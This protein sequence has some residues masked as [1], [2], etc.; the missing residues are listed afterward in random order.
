MKKI[1]M[2]LMVGMGAMNM[3]AAD[4]PRLHDQAIAGGQDSARLKF[5]FYPLLKCDEK[6]VVLR[7]AFGALIHLQNDG[8]GSV[9]FIRYRDLGLSLEPG[10]S[11]AMSLTIGWGDPT[12]SGVRY[13]SDDEDDGR[14]D[15]KRAEEQQEERERKA[16]LF[17]LGQIGISKFLTKE[18][19]DAKFARQL[20]S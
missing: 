1:M 6:G 2:C 14:D 7:T 8:D 10:Y 4:D 16:I 3:F 12:E 18:E 19:V 11:K 5:K 17:L 9:R 15:G 13:P 20:K